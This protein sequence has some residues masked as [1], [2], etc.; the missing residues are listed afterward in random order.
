MWFLGIRKFCYLARLKDSKV[1]W[2]NVGYD[3]HEFANHWTRIRAIRQRSLA[4]VHGQTAS[5]SLFT[6][7]IANLDFKFVAC[8]ENIANL[9]NFETI[10]L[11]NCDLVA[12]CL[13]VDSILVIRKLT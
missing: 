6:Q 10:D 11:D 5:F 12:H 4:V 8:C 1:S 9:I 3:G 7:L 2:E 13:S